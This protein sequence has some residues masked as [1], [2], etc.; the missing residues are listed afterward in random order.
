MPTDLIPVSDIEKMA[1][2]VA[3]SGLF[4]VKTQEQAFALMLVAQSENMHPA[5]AARDY[6]I[7]A[8][9]AA[10]TSEAMLR[11][12]LKS[13]GSVKWHALTDTEADATFTHPAGGEVRI[14]WDMTRAKTAGLNGK[15]MYKKFPR[16]MLRARCVSEG[17]RT[18]CPM[19]TGG[20]YTP[21]EVQDIPEKD[22]GA[23]VVVEQP[24]AKSKTE[25]EHPADPHRS[26]PGPTG[27]DSTNGVSPLRAASL[28][29]KGSVGTVTASV[30][31][32]S[33]A[34]AQD[35]APAVPDAPPPS[36]P[37]AAAV[38]SKPMLPAQVRIIKAK[39]KNAGVSDDDVAKAFGPIEDW[40]FD[41]FA[42]IS[43]WLQERAA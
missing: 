16:Q 29:E 10:K 11:D 22:M 13:G 9:K 6:N 26:S 15:D 17:V 8:G 3:K 24:R 2:A 31:K 40:Q 34:Q 5:A 1:S 23:A 37:A 4:G 28:D 30:P 38:P 7:I 43:T 42:P 27:S 20:M 19:A 33:A 12:F 32:S 18:V 35:A 21:E 39:M 14:T 36:A 41:D 25:A